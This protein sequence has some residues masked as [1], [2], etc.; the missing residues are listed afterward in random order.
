MARVDIS[1][2]R[3]ALMAGKMSPAADAPLRFA[4]SHLQIAPLISA[5]V[6]NQRREDGAFQGNHAGKGALI[7]VRAGAFR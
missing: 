5:R 1:R 7:P 2:S 4:G 3:Y 6:V